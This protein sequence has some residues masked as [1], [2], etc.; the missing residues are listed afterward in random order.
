MK[1]LYILRN[2]IKVCE[3]HAY[4][5]GLKNVSSYRSGQ[6]IPEGIYF[7]KQGNVC[8]CSHC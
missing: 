6:R 5:Q 2:K 3:K 4:F 1:V 8:R 7:N